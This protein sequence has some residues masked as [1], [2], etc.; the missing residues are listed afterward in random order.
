MDYK[1]NVQSVTET[2]KVRLWIS[3]DRCIVL[4]HGNDTT[5]AN[6]SI[7]FRPDGPHSLA[8]FERTTAQFGSWLLSTL[9]TILLCRSGKLP[10]D[11]P[12]M[13][14]Q[15]HPSAIGLAGR[16]NNGPRLGPL[17]WLALL[18]ASLPVRCG[19]SG[20][21]ARVG[22]IIDNGWLSCLVID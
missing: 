12:T 1:Q 4:F 6:I 11:N 8:L 16:H 21:G 5:R 9:Q 7:I 19:V 15:R 17:A 10:L 2:T 3:R 14:R 20:G 22:S 18:Y 13:P